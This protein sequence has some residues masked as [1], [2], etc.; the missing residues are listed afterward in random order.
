[1]QIRYIPPPESEAKVDIKDN[2]EILIT[3][4]FPT[5]TATSSFGS[6]IVKG[7][8]GKERRYVLAVSGGQGRVSAYEAKS[9]EPEFDKGQ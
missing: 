1:M 2:G 6:I 3:P 8:K 7:L 5:N 9:V 4:R